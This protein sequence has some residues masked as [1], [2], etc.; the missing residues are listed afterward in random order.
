MLYKCINRLSL[1][2]ISPQNNISSSL[3]QKKRSIKINICFQ[4]KKNLKMSLPLHFLFIVSE[5]FQIIFISDQKS[6]FSSL[7]YM[8]RPASTW[9]LSTFNRL[10]IFQK[11]L[12]F[13][14]KM[15][16]LIILWIVFTVT[17]LFFVY[18]KRS[19]VFSCWFQV[20]WFKWTVAVWTH[21]VWSTICCYSWINMLTWT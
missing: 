17:G 13:V 7:H 8:S 3:L 14:L 2:N 18:L 11:S 15:I 21:L 12:F 20:G 1:S 16:I 5:D 9:I 10:N 6:I 4:R 19:E